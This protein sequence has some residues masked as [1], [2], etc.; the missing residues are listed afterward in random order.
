MP[1]TP[2]SNNS[3]L[4]ANNTTN[5]PAYVDALEDVHTRF[6]LNLPPREL[7]TADR[8]FFQLEQAWWFYEDFLADSCDK[9]PHFL[10][11]KPFAAQLF[12]Y[13]PL[14][15]STKFHEMWNEFAAYK[16]QISTYGCI[17]LSQD[18]QKVVLCQLYKSETYTFPAGKVN[19]GEVGLAAACRETYEE[20]GFD[21]LCGAG[22]TK[23]WCTTRSNCVTT[24]T[25]GT[26]NNNNN[27]T[28]DTTSN[29]KITWSVSEADALV[30]QDDSGKS[31]TCFVC[32]NVPE[33]F[34]FEPVARKEVQNVSWHPLDQLPRKTFAVLPFLGQ[35][36]RWIKRH[37]VIHN[38]CSETEDTSTPTSTPARN[39]R[40]K[41]PRRK[42]ST[43]GS[44]T[45]TPSRPGSQG[46]NGRTPR[47]ARAQDTIV[48]SGLASAGDAS[49]W[50]E[51]EMFQV[52][53]KILG[54]KVEYDGNPHVF[55]E[56]GF[57]GKDPH[58]FHVVGGG[59]LN[60]SSNGSSA[61][62]PDPSK[63]QALFR[64]SND[65]TTSED[66][67]QPFFSNNGETPW[68][69]IVLEATTPTTCS[70]GKKNKPK[71]RG[72]QEPSNKTVV[73]A[74]TLQ[75]HKDKNDSTSIVEPNESSFLTD[76][77]IT[78]QSQRIKQQQQQQMQDIRDAYQTD[79]DFIRQW[80]ARLPPSKPTWYFGPAFRL[81]AD[82]IMA[83]A[84]ADSIR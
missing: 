74:P 55:A 45:T 6:L 77:E 40:N 76:C 30:F 43:G 5:N 3:S 52:N 39:K 20:T 61:A 13:S 47:I 69:D 11:F 49:G 35:L 23:V 80:V 58:A 66:A 44:A 41:T 60:A 70:S 64:S 28:D 22:V 81:D 79:T 26:D 27:T 21:P 4:L 71:S 56:Q 68:G 67:L 17:L 25:T 29:N 54:R 48:S 50:S 16:R 57:L 14:L 8:I 31:R 42:N 51:E 18:Y 32:Y 73:S 65:I 83:T 46:R 36:K 62:P 53:E 24:N 10:Q 15:P 7:E 38:N 9:L 84:A 1:E 75:Q 82:T 37:R 59:F 12:Q 72:K 2:N 63:L 33:D 34:P 19:Q 78:A